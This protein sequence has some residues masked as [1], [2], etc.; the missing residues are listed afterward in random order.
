MRQAEDA[1]TAMSAELDTLSSMPDDDVQEW[2][3]VK[4]D[5]EEQKGHQKEAREEFFRCKEAAHQ[6]RSAVQAES[7]NM[8]QKRD[9]LTARGIKLSEQRERLR[10]ATAEG[11]SE[12]ERR[13]AE[14]AAKTADRRQFEEK[15]LEQITNTERSIQ[16]ASVN[17][18]QAWQQTQI[19][20]SAFHQQQPMTNTAAA[21]EEPTTP[22]GDLPGT[23][24]R[25]A[26]T[27]TPA[28]R[29]P[30]FASNDHA[31]MRGA[32][33][34]SAFRHDN[35]PRSTSVLSGSSLYADFDDQDPAPPMPSMRPFG[36]LRGR[37]GSLSSGSGS[38]SGSSQRDPAS[39]ANGGIRMS[40]AEKR[41]SPIWN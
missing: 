18:Q 5:W 11:L 32:G 31:G 23:F 27:A 35:R 21:M 39:P 20:M 3:Q 13:E 33:G 38:G 17:A 28:F 24:S 37:Q 1:I 2:Q 12:K 29:F 7:T 19:I 15:S 16:E 9:R 41:G 22:E 10:S 26:P 6:E 4:R 14:I 30:P 8:Q 25:P 36:K 34:P 40:P